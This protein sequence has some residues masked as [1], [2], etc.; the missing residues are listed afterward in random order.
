MLIYPKHD[1]NYPNVFSEFCN[2]DQDDQLLDNVMHLAM[3]SW[4][5]PSRFDESELLIVK[6]KSEEIANSSDC[7]EQFGQSNEFRS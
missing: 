3:L 6:T 4:E 7:L 1:M 2:V 5:I